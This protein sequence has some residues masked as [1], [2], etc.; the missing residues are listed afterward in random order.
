[1]ELTP[2]VTTDSDS[3]PEQFADLSLEIAFFFIFGFYL[4]SCSRYREEKVEFIE[5]LCCRFIHV[6][7]IVIHR[8]PSSLGLSQG[9]YRDRR[10]D[11]T[12]RYLE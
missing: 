2:G 3:D 5:R 10:P 11:E 8:L 6:T 4:H 1:M 9:N 7:F 12:R